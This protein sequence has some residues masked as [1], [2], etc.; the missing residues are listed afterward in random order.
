MIK[1]YPSDKFSEQVVLGVAIM[2]SRQA[3]SV[4]TGLDD[5]DFYADNLKNRLIFK[6]MKAL[7]DAGK[8]ID[9]TTLTTQLLDLKDLDRVGGVNYLIELTNTV[10]NFTNV[11]FYITNL[12]DKTILRNLL[13]E[14]DKIEAEFE[15]TKI[16][17][18]NN[19]I[20][21]CEKRINKITN[22][23]RVSDFISSRDAARVVGER[24]QQSYG[25]ENS[26][27]GLPSGFASLDNMING[28]GKSE[29][30]ILAARPGVGK[31]AFAL[32]TGYNVASKSKKPVAVFSLEMSV[33]MIFKRLFA[34]TSCVNYDSI[35]RGY[36]TKE[37]RL[38]LKEAEGD[39]ANIPLY[40][41]DSSGA[42]ID[43]IVLKS[44]KL[45]ENLG[46]LGLIIVDYI[47][48]INDSKNIYK[49]NEQ[50]KIAAYSRRLKTLAMELECP[51][52]CLSQLNR[53]TE[54]RD[55][56]KPQLSDLRSSGAIEQDADKVIF[57]YR[58]AY[59]AEQG[60]TSTGTK[61]KG[62]GAPAAP[63]QPTPVVQSDND[64]VEILVAKNRSGKTGTVKVMFMK[65]FGRFSSLDKNRETQINSLKNKYESIDD[66]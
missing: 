29:L 62:E 23:R 39:L 65:N 45:K 2:D 6:A 57:L 10:T 21:D 12:R 55:N 9:I 31:S 4:I 59:Y 61:K 63:I 5:D 52:L 20:A 53:Q 11:D 40:V 66:D 56:K 30:I 37:E 17:N 50:A 34:A 47:G 60:I 14:I 36:L 28:L 54:A 49:D 27:T 7:Y 33:D 22:K 51:V 42:T 16:D 19:F 44:R 8:G 43:D 18:V 13:I 41:D 1:E 25:L 35:T 3:A 38:K 32:N 24:I 46:D 58:D 26:I 15:S 48:L 64:I